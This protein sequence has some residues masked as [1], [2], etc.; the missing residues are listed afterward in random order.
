MGLR[1]GGMGRGVGRVWWGLEKECR[2]GFGLAWLG[3]AG[4]ERI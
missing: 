4:L 2:V 3:W 1:D